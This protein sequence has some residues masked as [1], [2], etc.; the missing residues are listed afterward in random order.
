MK[1][2]R[3]AGE[4]MIDQWFDGGEKDIKHVK[5]IRKYY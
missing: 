1:K 3:R 5:G 2:A 4:W